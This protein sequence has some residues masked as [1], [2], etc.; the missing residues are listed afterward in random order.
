MARGK[1]AGGAAVVTVLLVI[2]ACAG[3]TAALRIPGCPHKFKASLQHL[4]K[5]YPTST[6]DDMLLVRRLLGC[7]VQG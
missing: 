6:M 4:Y 1:Y 5:Q 2:L 3:T 7:D